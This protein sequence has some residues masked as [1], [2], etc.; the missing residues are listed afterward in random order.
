[1]KLKH[2]KR[3]GILNKLWH[4]LGLYDIPLG[5]VRGIW[6]RREKQGNAWVKVYREG[7]APV[8]LPMFICKPL[9]PA[10]PRLFTPSTE[11]VKPRA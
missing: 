10:L 5:D 9:N 7:Y 4:Q 8:G 2:Y 3:T 11:Q 1:M 6:Y